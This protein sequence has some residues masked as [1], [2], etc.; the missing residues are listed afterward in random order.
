MEEKKEF[1]K[2]QKRKDN[3]KP[4]KKATTDLNMNILSYVNLL[5]RMFS[6]LFQIYLIIAKL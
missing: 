6:F 5:S 1:K 4:F 3:K 2:D